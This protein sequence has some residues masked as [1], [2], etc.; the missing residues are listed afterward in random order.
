MSWQVVEKDGYGTY[1]AAVRYAE[2]GLQLALTKFDSEEEAIK[3]ATDYL[4]ARKQVK[5][6]EKY[7]IR[8]LGEI[9]GKNFFSR[10]KTLYEALEQFVEK[11]DCDEQKNENLKQKNRLNDLMNTPKN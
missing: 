4:S 5:K 8:N 2:K 11:L 7:L 1:W 6:D 10:P 3:A 9:D